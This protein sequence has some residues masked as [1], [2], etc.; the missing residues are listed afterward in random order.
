MTEQ[1]DESTTVP[2]LPELWRGQCLNVFAR[3]ED[4][5]IRALEAAV[6]GE[7]TRKIPH[8]AGQRLAVL[9]ILARQ[10]SFTDKQRERFEAVMAD[11]KAIE[12]KRL[13]LAHGVATA[14]R[15]NNGAWIV[16]FDVTV[17]RANRPLHDRWAI[18]QS[19]AI[20]FA[21]E[22]TAAHAKVCQQLGILRVQKFGAEKKALPDPNEGST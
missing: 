2:F 18:K 20:A 6:E 4:A 15:E 10:A 7:L 21:K 16:L 14:A 22:L 13:F 9:E 17:Y 11:W 8:L 19:E 12:A 5:V 1:K 3:V